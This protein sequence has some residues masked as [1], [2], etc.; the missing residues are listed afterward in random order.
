M[1]E[2]RALCPKCKKDVMFIRQ[3]GWSSCPECGFQFQGGSLEPS[4][5]GMEH[6]PA[7]LSLLN[8]ILA[9]FLISIVLVLVGAAVLFAG[10]L[11][12]AGGR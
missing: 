1:N 11:V 2:L 7:Q 5:S 6:R 9:A 10:C 12:M 4:S 3:Q 8:I